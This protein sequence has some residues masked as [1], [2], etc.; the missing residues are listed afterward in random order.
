[1]V[2]VLLDDRR[3]DV[4]HFHQFTT[5]LRHCDVE[6][7]LEAAATV[8]L[9]PHLRPHLVQWWLAARRLALPRR[10]HPEKRTVHQPPGGGHLPEH[11]RAVHHAPLPRPLAF[12][13]PRVCGGCGGCGSDGCVDEMCLAMSHHGCTKLGWQN[14]WESD[15][16]RPRHP[17][18]QR[19]GGRSAKMPFL[20]RES[21]PQTSITLAV[22]ESVAPPAVPLDSWT[23]TGMSTTSSRTGCRNPSVFCTVWTKHLSCITTGRNQN[24]LLSKNCTCEISGLLHS[25]HC[26]VPSL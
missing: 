1:M 25:L 11:S 18:P 22:N 7:E 8:P 19:P 10:R 26:G 20:R 13:C 9:V 17:G 12:V 15:S 5:Q 6:N 24:T 16:W 21:P 23:T 4:R 3:H 14:T 2:N